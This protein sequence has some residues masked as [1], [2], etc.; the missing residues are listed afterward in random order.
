MEGSV[1]DHPLVVQVLRVLPSVNGPSC[2]Q[3]G[4]VADPTEVSAV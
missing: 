2:R 4:Q 1:E 3:E